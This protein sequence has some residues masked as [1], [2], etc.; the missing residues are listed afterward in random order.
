M[1]VFGSSSEE[2]VNFVESLGLEDLPLTGSKY[3]FFEGGKGIA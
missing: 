3:T 2:L 1:N